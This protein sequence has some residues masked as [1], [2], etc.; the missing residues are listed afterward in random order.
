MVIKNKS[1][2]IL[3]G[4][5]FL[6][7]FL[8]FYHIREL[9]TFRGDQAIELTGAANIL[10]GKFTLIGIKTSNSELHNGA[11]MYYL[12]APFL[13]LF[14]FDPVAGGVLQSILSLATIPIVYLL[15]KKFANEKIALLSAFIVATSSLL[16]HF[17]RQTLLAFY[18]LFFSGLAFFLVTL[19]TRKFDKY[20][21]LILGILLGFMLQVHYSTL[22]V[23]LFTLAIGLFFIPQKFKLKYYLF[24]IV[25]F[26]IGFLPMIIF[27]LRHEFFNTKMLI[28]LVKGLQRGSNISAFNILSYWQNTIS[29]LFLGQK[30][31][32]GNFFLPLI[33]LYL[34][35]KKKLSLLEKL[36]LLQIFSTFLFS[37]VFVHQNTEHYLITAYIPLIILTTSAVYNISNALKNKLAKAS[38]F[39]VFLFGLFI[40]NFYSSGFF[41][42]HGWTMDDGWNLPG[43][44]KTAKIIAN[45]LT[46][47]SYNVVMVVDAENQGLP[48]RYFLDIWGK[49][50]LPVEKYDKALYLYVVTQPK[51]KLSEISMFEINSFGAYNIDKT[52]PIQNGFT[53]FRLSHRTV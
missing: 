39:I 35:W 48:L 51:I 33:S 49:T 10:K 7:F 29:L 19:I 4:I 42:N 40:L 24:T 17:S 30:I 20:F 53:L 16:I 15:G 23:F 14:H 43:L 32:L 9:T 38:I 45:D 12:L 52:W 21:W 34:I 3:I 46:T 25:G 41:D 50:P 18:P 2:L 47:S 1:A 6:G 44:E 26:L 27:E 28:S 8:R 11:V 22:A 13:F 36:S 37:L 31:F 5:I